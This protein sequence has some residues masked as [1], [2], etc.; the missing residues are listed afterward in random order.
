MA[1]RVVTQIAEHF[2]CDVRDI[3]EYDYQPGQWNRPVYA[4]F[5]GNA[6]WSA[7]GV[8]PPKHRTGD[9]GLAWERVASNY[10]G[11]AHLWRAR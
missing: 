6:Y 8:K 11:N 3:S 10:P 4:G 9:D 7:G 5:D 1:K 2:G